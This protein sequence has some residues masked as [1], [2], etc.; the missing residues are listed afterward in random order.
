MQTKHAWVSLI[1]AA[2]GWMI[3]LMTL[4]P[5]STF[6]T[7]QISAA[8]KFTTYFL[9]LGSFLPAIFALGCAASAMRLRGDF[10]KLATCGLVAAG[11]HLGLAI[12]LIV[13]NI[14][15]N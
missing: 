11:S 8:I 9:F 14:W 13:L 2:G 15:H 1:L 4:A 3:L 7:G 12:G 6:H 10:G 5:Y